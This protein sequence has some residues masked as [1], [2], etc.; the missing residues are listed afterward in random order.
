MDRRAA[1]GAP[2]IGA[3]DGPREC[4]AARGLNVT[5]PR[6]TPTARQIAAAIISGLVSHVIAW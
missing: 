5:P 2:W 1:G 6:V 4:L 3:M